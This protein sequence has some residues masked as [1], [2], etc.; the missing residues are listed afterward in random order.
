[1]ARKAREGDSGDTWLNTYAD[2][3]TLLLTFFVVMLSM[4]VIES[5]KFDILVKSLTPGTER[6]VALPGDAEVY[7][8]RPPIEG[9]SMDTLY[10]MIQTY[11]LENQME[12]AMSVSKVEDIVYIRFSSAMLFEPDRYTMLQSSRPLVGFVGEVLKLYEDSIKTINICGHTARTGRINS[13]V[14]DW[15]LSGERAATVAMFFEDESEIDK[16]KMITFGYGDNY[17]IADNETEDG[18]SQN[19]RVELVV[20]GVDS[21]ANFDV[22][23]VLSDITEGDGFASSGS[24]Q[25]IL[26]PGGPAVL[27][28]PA[29]PGE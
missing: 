10:E 28:E 15:R 24:A 12:S 19:R 20:V 16:N 18:R 14:S 17:P 8:E 3:V 13:D 2:M 6:G 29:V 22:Y 1:M 21:L 27:G 5:E 23:G 4:S 7:I 9:K 11:V 25:D 26:T